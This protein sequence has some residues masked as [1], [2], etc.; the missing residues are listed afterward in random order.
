MRTRT[1]W[2]AVSPGATPLSMSKRGQQI[3]ALFQHGERLHIAGRLTEAEQ[4]YRQVLAAAPRHAAGLHALGALALQSGRADAADA[5]I[6]QAIAQKP[7]A[8][9][10]L[11]HAHALLALG[12][13]QQAAQACRLVLRAQPGN[14]HAH[15]TL[16]HALSDSL[17][18]DGALAAYRQAQRLNPA[19]PDIGNNIGTALRQANRLE[20]AEQA[21]LAA[22]PEVATLVNLS[23]V[24]KERGA[25]DRAEATL[26]RALS[27]APADPVVSYNWSLLML[28]LDRPDEGWPAWEHRFRA[29]AIP[30]PSQ[31]GP[32]WD[33]D[34]LGD[35]ALLVQPEQGLGDI[36]QFCRYLPA[37]TGRVTFDAPPRLRRLLA[38]NPAMPLAPLPRYDVVAPLL[39]LPARMRQPPARPPYLFAE[40]GLV[41]AWRDRIG[42]DGF[43]IGIA[44][45]GF[46]GRHED[47][48]R[49][50]PLAAFQPLARPDV[51]LISLQKH[52]GE[53][54]IAA[55]GFAVERLDGLDDGPDAFVDTAAVMATLDLVVTSDTSIA[56]LA[57]ALGC[58]VWVALRRVPDWRWMI[59]RPDSPWYPSMRLFRQSQDGDWPPVFAAMAQ[60]LTETMR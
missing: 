23:S 7:A 5:L 18:A 12:R 50:I 13:P 48:G 30:A 46:S 54:Q 20:D 24:Q 19:L 56:H 32:Q 59:D 40:P 37:I 2:T 1:R 38:S 6:R 42:G 58:P 28:L 60:A 51:R 14:P 17:D 29:G 15:Q 10:H 47:K 57:G 25:F 16:G 45:Q 53:D 43:R 21:L 41:T 35:R 8:A 52:E 49:S 33:G 55:A 34:A 31:A 26:R 27:V 11:T 36:I 44:W 9:F 22:P 39:S 3:E 4:A